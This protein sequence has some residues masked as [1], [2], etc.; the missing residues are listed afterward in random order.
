MDE[1][2]F[3]EGY[4]NVRLHISTTE[5]LKQCGD[6]GQTYDDIINKLMRVYND[7]L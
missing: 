7:S 5:L 3:Y 2:N 4:R 6:K 1:D